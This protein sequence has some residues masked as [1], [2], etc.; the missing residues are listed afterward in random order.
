MDGL[1]CQA[2][3]VT[4][5]RLAADAVCP[6]CAANTT[7]AQ[8]AVRAAP[9]VTAVWLWASSEAATAI[10]TRD[11]PTILRAYR[12][13]NGLNQIALAEHL[14]YDKSYVSMIETGRRAIS[15]VTSRRHIASR[16][17]LPAHV[18]GVTGTDDAEFR[19]MLQFGDSTVRLAEIAPG[20]ACSR[21]S[22][23]TMAMGGTARGPRRRRPYGT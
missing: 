14:G 19:A 15:D 21:S 3:G 5:S 16:L 1:R 23:R 8:P 7:P 20:R 12:R 22:Q 18:L 11:L 17:G 9:I 10:A 6:T 13:L 2:C 4:I